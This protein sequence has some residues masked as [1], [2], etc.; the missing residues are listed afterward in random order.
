MSITQ[1]TISSKVMGFLDLTSAKAM[2][3]CM[4]L[5]TFFTYCGTLQLKFTSTKAKRLSS[6]HDRCL[7]IINW[8]LKYAIALP[9]VAKAE[10]ARACTLVRKCF[11]FVRTSKGILS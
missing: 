1:I 7:K 9:L 4:I 2:Y 10:W 8:K 3:D 5:P 11:V 6:F